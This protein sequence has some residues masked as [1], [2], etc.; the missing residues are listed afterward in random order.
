MNAGDV[1]LYAVKPRRLQ[2]RKPE[3]RFVHIADV[4]FR[5]TGRYKPAGII[6]FVSAMAVYN[7]GE[8]AK[9]YKHGSDDGIRNVL[10]YL[11]KECT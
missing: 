4:P 1:R 6:L 11:K 2:V 9:G 10:E 3:E 5:F 7:I 8:Y